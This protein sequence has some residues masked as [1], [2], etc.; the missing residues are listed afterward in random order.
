MNLA[1]LVDQ[2]EANKPDASAYVETIISDNASENTA[3]GDVSDS[4]EFPQAI[5]PPSNQS[6]PGESAPRSRARLTAGEARRA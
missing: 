5:L 2:F 3:P 4:V 1:T 6:A